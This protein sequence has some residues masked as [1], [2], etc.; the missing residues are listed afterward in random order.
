MDRFSVRIDHQATAADHISGR[1]FVVENG[2]FASFLSGGTDKFGNWGGFGIATRN[3]MGEY[4]RILSSSMLNEVRVGFSQERDFRTPQNLD[5][6]PSRLI[7]GLIPPVAG[8][9]GLPTVTVT[10][11]R[12]FSDPPGS[13]DIKRTY[14]IIERLTWTNNRHA[15][16]VGFEWQRA[17]AFNFQNPPPFRGSFTFDGRYSGHPFA[18]FLLGAVAATGRVS[19]NVEAEPVN[20]RY[21]AYI[22]DDWV[23]TPRLT[24]NLGLRYEYASLFKNARHDLA[25]FYPELGQVVVLDGQGDPRL[26][27]ALPIVEGA[28]VGLG[29]DN[30]VNK[31]RNNF[32]PRV[33]FAFRP[34]GT[35]RLVARG[36][37]GIFYNVIPA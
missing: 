15:V 23:A 14:E 13:G 18:D 32:A 8:L 21:G 4:T 28:S 11:F 24:L 17:S 36:S 37:Y 19:R 31:D 1:F 16:K 35:T 12:G 25:N 6:D 3:A 10:G 9:G 26:L 20:D 34:L 27:A 29:P 30:Y 2:P 5:F 22:Q 7:P 33:G